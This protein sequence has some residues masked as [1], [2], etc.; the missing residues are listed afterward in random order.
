MAQVGRRAAG[1]L[2]EVDHVSRDWARVGPVLA[3]SRPEW[4]RLL[5]MGVGPAAGGQARLLDTAPA[6]SDGP[7]QM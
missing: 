7:R 4:A 1:E 6:S 5:D 2:V 3:G